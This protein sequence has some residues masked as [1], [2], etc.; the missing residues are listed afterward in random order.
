MIEDTGPGG[1]SKAST[2]F[3]EKTAKAPSVGE[4]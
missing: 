3:I 2:N 4:A 1:K